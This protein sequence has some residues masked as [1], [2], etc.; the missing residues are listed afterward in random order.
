MIVEMV[1]THCFHQPFRELSIDGVR[2][3]GMRPHYDD[4]KHN[5]P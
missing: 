4:V 1:L 5:P 2:F 3:H